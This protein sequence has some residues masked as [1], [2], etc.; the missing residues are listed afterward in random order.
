M[1]RATASMSALT[2]FNVTGSLDLWPRETPGA[3]AMRQA[4]HHAANR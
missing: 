2:K 4:M 1:V 3:A